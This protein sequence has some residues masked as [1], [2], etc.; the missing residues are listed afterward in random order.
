[1]ETLSRLKKRL[2]NNGGRSAALKD[3][4]LKIRRKYGH[5]DLRELETL[6]VEIFILNSIPTKIL[7]RSLKLWRP[8]SGLHIL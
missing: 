8:K 6:K 4:M 7:I 1:M 5:L 3:G 2:G